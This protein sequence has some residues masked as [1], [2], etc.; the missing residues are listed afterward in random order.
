[1]SARRARLRAVRRRRR[2]RRGARAGRVLAPSF[3]GSE[4]K[5]PLAA[6]GAAAH[7]RL[8]ARASQSSSRVRA[9]ARRGRPRDAALHALVPSAE[10][11]LTE[12]PARRAAARPRRGRVRAAASRAASETPRART[13]RVRAFGRSADRAFARAA[14]ALSPGA[15]RTASRRTPPPRRAAAPETKRNASRGGDSVGLVK[16]RALLILVKR[17]GARLTV[18]AAECHESARATR[19]EARVVPRA[20]AAGVTRG[21]RAATVGWVE[22]RARA[23]VS[24][25]LASAPRSD[26]WS[27]ACLGNLFSSSEAHA[28]WSI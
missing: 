1:M 19:E 23:R 12:P 5:V 21:E 16:P 8:R 6:G 17:E 3:F 11:T 25:A 2:R 14:V 4:A 13:P 20:G 7:L 9:R 15:E 28:V 10:G 27:C 24:N 22:T 26:L 18:T